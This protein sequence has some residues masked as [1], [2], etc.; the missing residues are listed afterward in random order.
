MQFCYLSNN[1][2]I[3]DSNSSRKSRNFGIC[4]LNLQKQLKLFLFWLVCNS[5]YNERK[6]HMNSIW[7]PICEHYVYFIELIHNLFAFLHYIF[8]NCNYSKRKSDIYNENNHRE[9]HHY[10]VF[11][12][13]EKDFF[14]LIFLFRCVEL[15]F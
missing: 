8:V 3:D 11:F 7:T 14:L 5:N 6:H 12:R 4:F 9:S 13:V 15:P 10:V 1:L 2:T